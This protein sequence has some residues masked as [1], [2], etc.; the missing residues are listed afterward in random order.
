MKLAIF[1]VLLTTI[2][3]F[4][5]RK[6]TETMMLSFLI[7]PVNDILVNL[8]DVFL[9][10]YLPSSPRQN[11]GEGSPFPFAKECDKAGLAEGEPSGRR[12]PRCP[13]FLSCTYP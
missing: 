12:H 5:G 8:N 13:A 4:N 1:P 11:I 2:S 10:I 9:H 6:I 7:L 3:I